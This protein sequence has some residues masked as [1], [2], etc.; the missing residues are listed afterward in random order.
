[1]FYSVAALTSLVSECDTFWEQAN[2]PSARRVKLI[3][4]S[5]KQTSNQSTM[6]LQLC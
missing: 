5:D 6:A 4:Q 3:R 2:K 1:M